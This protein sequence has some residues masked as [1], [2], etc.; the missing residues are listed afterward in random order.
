MKLYH[1]SQTDRDDYDT[2]SDMVVCASSEDEARHIHPCYGGWGNDSMGCWAREPEMVTV[3]YIGEAATNLEA[4][5]IC[6]SFHA[7]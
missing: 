3:E 5:I 2:Y 1:I 7:G 4:G 6:S